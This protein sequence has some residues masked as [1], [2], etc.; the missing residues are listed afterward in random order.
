MNQLRKSKQI[1]A[2]NGIANTFIILGLFFLFSSLAAILAPIPVFLYF[3]VPLEAESMT[4][5]LNFGNLR[6]HPSGRLIYLYIQGIS[7]LGGFILSAV[8]YLRYI[9]KANISPLNLRPDWRWLSFVLAALVTISIMPF[10]SLLI[11]WNSDI[12]LPAY[13][14][15]LEAWII[16][17]EAFFQE[18]TVFL[19]Q[20]GSSGEALIALLVMAIL[21]G[22][23]EELLF[24]GLI[25]RN[26]QAFLNPHVAIWLSAIIFSAIHLQFLGFIPRALLGALFGYLY[27]WSG[28]IWLAILAHF[29][30]NAFTLLMVYAYHLGLIEHNILGSQA[31]TS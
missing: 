2:S 10:T 3:Q 23:G 16:E 6:E 20:F 18:L 27:Y 5:F 12:H 22:I 15:E 4:S 8:I 19:T 17:K 9:E 26:F 13:L 14:S 28:N 25:Q 21:P 30:N 1:P 7:S 24:R 29:V 11:E 31:S